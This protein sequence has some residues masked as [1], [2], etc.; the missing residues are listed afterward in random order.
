MN[1]DI[2]DPL[3]IHTLIVQLQRDE[4]IRLKPYMDSVGKLTI[5]IGRNLDDTGISQSEAEYM[6]RN[7]ISRA[8]T[9]LHNALPWTDTL[10]TARFGV[11]VN[12]T[13]NMGIAGLCGFKN[14]LEMIKQGKYREAAAAMLESKWAEQVGPRAHRL[15]K[16]MET[17][18][19]Q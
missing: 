13:F 9:D 2:R 18:I 12:M 8:I 7:D 10:D 5:G 3:T 16:Q 1:D 17:G 6:V 19:W 11:L 4:G 15:S 14:T